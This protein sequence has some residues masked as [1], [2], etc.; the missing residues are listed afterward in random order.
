[1][2]QFVARKK[3]TIQGKTLY[4][5]VVLEKRDPRGRRYYWIGDGEL[6]HEKIPGSDIAAIL[7]HHVSVTP[8]HFNM[9][10]EASLATLHT[11]LADE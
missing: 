11:L 6:S 7:D 9:T 4:S 8:L 3:M 10:H 1:M 2:Q 5:D